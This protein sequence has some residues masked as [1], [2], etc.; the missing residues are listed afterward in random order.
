M[1]DCFID[2]KCKQKDLPPTPQI[3]YPYK[4]IL[5]EIVHGLNRWTT[6]QKF[7]SYVCNTFLPLLKKNIKFP[8]L[9]LIDGHRSHFAYNV[10]KFCVDNEILLFALLP[11]ATHIL[12]PADVSSVM[13]PE[14]AEEF[15]KSFSNGCTGDDCA[16]ELFN[17]WKKLRSRC[18]E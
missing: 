15:R 1:F 9:Y 17:V 2:P 6:G 12:Q 4:R 10:S 14:R 3:I 11:N 18:L 8:I 16:K 5:A 13:K 7:Y